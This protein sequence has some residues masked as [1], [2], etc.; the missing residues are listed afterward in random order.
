MR[1]AI[2]G[3]GPAG[4]AAAVKLRDLGYRDVKIFEKADRVGGKAMSVEVDGRH[5]DLGAV[6]ISDRCRHAMELAKR[7][8]LQLSS[9]S[10]TRSVVDLANQRWADIVDAHAEKYSARQ[11]LIMLAR[12]QH[13]V[14]KYRR[15]FDRPGFAF[16][17]FPE[18][19]S[20]RQE[21]AQPMSDWARANKLELLLP[22]WEPAVANMGYG[23]YSSVAAQYLLKYMLCHPRMSVRQALWTMVSRRAAPMLSFTSGY[24]AL[25]EAVARD[26]DVTTGT[27]I[28]RICRS[29][30]G[31]IIHCAGHAEPQRFDKVLLAMPLDAAADLLAD[32]TPAGLAEETASV[33]KR[34]EYT[35]YYGTLAESSALFDDAEMH[36]A[37]GAEQLGHAGGHS[38]IRPWSDSKLRV[39]YHYGDPDNP[40]NADAAVDRLRRDLA[41]VGISLG[42]VLHTQQWRYFPRF[43][44]ADVA[45]GL[46]DRA[47]ALQGKLNTYFLG[48]AMAF[49]MVEHTIDFSYHMVQREFADVN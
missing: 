16:T 44:C 29:Q 34:L 10:G 2:V 7:Y 15:F 27:T 48:S 41:H 45:A 21:I 13:Y 47:D 14:S 17:G 35:E 18:L 5:Y 39:F 24:Q 1:I 28:T 9:L 8:G 38:S 49:E 33:F 25:F 6:L 11:R 46:Y 12:A 40:W 42:S 22:A 19:E 31:V 30:D 37:Y 20:L 32:D 26:F 36:F 23:P 43:S 3:A 4:L